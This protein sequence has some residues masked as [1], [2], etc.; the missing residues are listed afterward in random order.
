MSAFEFAPAG[1][2]ARDVVPWRSII[3]RPKIGRR[4]AISV[5]RGWAARCIRRSSSSQYVT[6]VARAFREAR[7]ATGTP[8]PPNRAENY[9]EMG[10]GSVEPCVG[11]VGRGDLLRGSRRLLITAKGT[12]NGPPFGGAQI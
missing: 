3:G 2:I 12:P 7:T 11:V 4:K 9:W 6:S 1:N 8:G 10:A 5:R